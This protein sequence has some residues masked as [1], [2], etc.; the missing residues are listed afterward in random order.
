N[1]PDSGTNPEQQIAMPY[2]RVT[3]A[4]GNA[5]TDSN[6]NFTIPGASA[7]LSVTVSY[8]GTYCATNNQAQGD[9]SLNVVLNAASGNQILMNPAAATLV[10]PEANGFNWVGRMRDWTRAV[11]PADATSDFLAT[12]NVNI[13]STCNA[14][15]DGSSVNYY[16]AGGGCVNTAY[17]SVVL[18]EMGHWLND[19][20]GS[21]NGPD[22]FGEGNADNFSTHILDDP[23]VGMDFCGVGCH[24]RDAN[25]NQQF[26]GDSNPGCWGGVH[27]NGEVLMGALWKVRTR[28]KN[29]LG[30]P[31]GIAAS[32]TLFN[33]WLNAYND[34]EIKSIIELRY[35]TLD[36]NDGNI[37]NGTPNYSDIDG[38]FMQQGF[39]GFPL[40]YVVFSNVT[41]LPDTQNE[42]GPYV[43]Q[44]DIVANLAP[45]LAGAE[46]R[47]RVNG[48]AFQVVPM[49]PIA[50]PTYGALI[51]GQTAPAKVEYYLTAQ[52][53]NGNSND[54]PTL[55]SATPIKFLV[56]V[57]NVYFVADFESGAAGW[58]HSAN[59]G[60]QDDWQISSQ[61]G[62]D[63]SFGKVGDPTYAPSG[64]N[65]WGNDLGPS[66]WNGLYSSNV[67]NWLRSPSIDLSQATNSTLVLQRWL[68]V[69][70]AN[71]DQAR[72][73][74]NGQQVWINPTGQNL[75]D[76]NWV[77]MEID[78]SAIADGNP[79]VQVEFSLDTNGSTTFGGW[80]IDD[81]MIQSLTSGGCPP[82]TSYCTAKL[83]S[84]LTVPEIGSSGS[85]S[86]AAGNFQVTLAGAI[87]N[88]ASIVI[89]GADA[90]STPFNGGVLCVGPP[91]TRGP[92]Q[93]TSGTGATAFTPTILPADVGTTRRFQWW[94]RDIGDSQGTGLSDGLAVTFCD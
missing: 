15:Y 6:G 79:A 91:I 54:F 2:L 80:N 85:P 37:N 7:P 44:A 58:T 73:R 20:Y 16:Q 77:E 17:S 40:P 74:V 22:G 78:I 43:V 24:V 28:L 10:T 5:I 64:T 45:P 69:E 66:G 19:R 68:Q 25:N 33:A 92:L 59:G 32:N 57:L 63:T 14:Y 60:T 53:N 29:S 83:T 38:G 93:F 27:A 12:S 72:I 36:D 46:L 87:P 86:Q 4:Q 42:V 3:S 1:A 94:F 39:P 51:P 81:V 67:S 88:A 55:G 18:H 82:P 62:V 76:T 34:S 35:L 90:A 56:G 30:A 41:D 70:N 9:Y 65:I 31:A 11:N 89:W 21:G 50:G 48:G 84:A 47:Y 13:S 75:I 52:D 61:F 23:I 71:A 49:T 8:D 26:C